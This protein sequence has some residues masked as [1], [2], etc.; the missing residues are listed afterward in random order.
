MLWR[1]RFQPSVQPQPS[2]APRRCTTRWAITAWA[3]GAGAF[4]L[5]LVPGLFAPI[6]ASARSVAAPPISTAL[7][8]VDAVFHQDNGTTALDGPYYLTM[9]DDGKFLYNTCSWGEGVGVYSR[10]IETG[11]LTQ[12][13]ALS[14]PAPNHYGTSGPVVVRLSADGKSAYVPAVYS[15]VVFSFSR[16]TTSGLL[17]KIQGITID[18]DPVVAP[19]FSVPYEE[20]VLDSVPSP[21]GKF[22]Y[23]AAYWS[24]A[25]FT[26]SR[27]ETTGLLT[28]I[29]VDHNGENGVQNFL[30]PAQLTITP[31]GKFLYAGTYGDQDLPLAHNGGI[32]CFSLDPN[33]GTPTYVS[34]AINGAGGVTSVDEVR[35]LALSPDMKTLYANAWLSNSIAV[36]SRD[37]NTGALTQVQEIRNS[38]ELAPV[39]GGL[40]GSRAS[41]VSPDGRY[42]V[43]I[44]YFDS[45][46]LAFRRDTTTG[47]LTYVDQYRTG[48][49]APGVIPAMQDLRGL[50]FSPDS[51]FVYVCG[52]ES[53]SIHSFAISD[54]ISS[55]SDSWALLQE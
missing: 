47:L 16:E 5:S 6:P 44:S 2:A 53:D 48:T 34:A 45:A 27:N 22:V 9:S 14:L 50:A 7:T 35:W 8:Y 33:T 1:N 51:R 17:T 37:L 46:V 25:L 23:A 19:P 24:N 28:L 30:H 10:N 41:A 43:S 38:V 26:F 21:N 15:D 49:A 40:S 18:V 4:A 55:A 39:G 12:I 29:R 52:W 20:W 11:A 3:L 36:F 13:Q 54:R 31:D 32:V 42:L